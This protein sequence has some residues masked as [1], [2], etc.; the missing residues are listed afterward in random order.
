MYQYH[1]QFLNI[2]SDRI[3]IFLLLLSPVSVNSSTI[4][5]DFF[6]WKVNL[7]SQWVFFQFFSWFL[8]IFH[9]FSMISHGFSWFFMFFSMF[10][11]LN[12]WIW[13]PSTSSIGICLGPDHQGPWNSKSSA[14]AWRP[15][16][17]GWS[18]IGNDTL[19]LFNIYI[20]YNNNNNNNSNNSNNN[21]SNNNNNI[22]IYIIYN[23]Y[24]Y[25]LYTYMWKLANL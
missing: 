3:F 4:W 8:V 23:I 17:F 12:G 7:V 21:S 1:H 5:V 2:S 13:P 10:F 25:T 22:Y 11:H 9:V 18:K 14:V 19:W 20:I 6:F 24:I 15:Y 16:G